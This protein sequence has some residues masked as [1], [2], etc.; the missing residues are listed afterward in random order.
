MQLVRAIDAVATALSPR[1]PAASFSA[2]ADRREELV[3]TLLA[4]LNHRPANETVVQ[5]QDRLANVSSSQRN[6]AVTAARGIAE[7]ARKIREALARKA[8]E[9]S[10]DKMWRE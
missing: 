1:A 5:A 4:A 8:A 7:R 2:D 3:R 10:A 9:E 6:I